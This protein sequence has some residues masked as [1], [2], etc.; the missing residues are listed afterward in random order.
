V[1]DVIRSAPAVLEE[2]ITAGIEHSC[3]LTVE[4]RALGWGWHDFGRLGD[5]SPGADGVAGG[6]T[7]R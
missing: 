1:A 5:E 7:F 2:T 4:G 6:L 3:G